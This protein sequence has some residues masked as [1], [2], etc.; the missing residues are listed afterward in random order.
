P[1]ATDP[2]VFA[3]NAVPPSRTG[4]VP[5]AGLHSQVVGK[6]G[7]TSRDRTFPKVA[8]G[9]FDDVLRATRVSDVKVRVPHAPNADAPAETLTVD[10][11]L[12]RFF[13]PADPVFLL[14]GA[15]RSYKHGF[16]GQ[17]AESGKL[18]CRLSGHTVTGLSPTRLARM[19]GGAVRGEDLL[20]RGIDHGG[21]PLECEDLLRE[22]ALLDPGSAETAAATRVTVDR[23]AG[24]G[25]AREARAR[26]AGIAEVYA[27]E[28]TAWWVG[29]DDRR[30]LSPLLAASG[31]AG[32]LPSAVA[33]SLPARPWVPLHLD[34]EVQLFASPRLADW[35]LE[36]VDFDAVPATVPAPDATPHRTLS[37]RALL[38]GGAAKVAAATVRK[39]LEQAQQ[40]AGSTTLTP[41]VRH[42]FHSIAA[43]QMVQ[44]IGL[45][46]SAYAVKANERRAEVHGGATPEAAEAA[47]AEDLDHI[48]DEL[49]Q[50]DV[51]VGAMDRFNSQLREGFIAD[52]VAAPPPGEPVPIDFWPLRAGFLR[53]TRLRL[54]DCFGQTLDLLGSGA[55]QPA[56]TEDLLRSEPLTVEG[57]PDLVELAPRFTAPSRLWFRFVS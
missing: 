4:T 15:G 18:V 48:A 46:A 22:L 14:E 30:D 44:K 20:Q 37:G 3:A 36:E 52:G 38:G 17:Y 29:R 10:R 56:R 8:K 53:V 55:G 31:L 41:G 33:V 34:W 13:V 50:M 43:Q 40:T 25:I 6:V 7:S 5:S 28:Q 16:D 1:S 47:S 32:T 19:A 11:A 39:V 26:I 21:V 42:A 45:M 54:V 51:L 27:V 23:A 35:Q 12:P 9:T 2:G 24:G 49:E 57:R